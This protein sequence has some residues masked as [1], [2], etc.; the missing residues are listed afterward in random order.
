MA[1]LNRRED[2][3]A[4]AERDRIENERWQIDQRNERII[5]GMIG[6]EI[7]LPI[8]LAI[9]GDRRQTE[10]VNK[11]LDA[12]KNMQV[13]LVKLEETSKATADAMIALTEKNGTRK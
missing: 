13:A 5:I 3:R 2:Q 8:G 6:V 11:Q 12:L 1:E 9:W 4:Q 7:I 10:H